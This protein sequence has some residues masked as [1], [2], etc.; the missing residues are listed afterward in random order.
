MQIGLTV[1]VFISKFICLFSS[2][3]RQCQ[4]YYAAFRRRRLSPFVCAVLLLILHCK[5]DYEYVNWFS[6]IFVSSAVACAHS[7][8]SSSFHLSFIFVRE[9]KCCLFTFAIRH[10]AFGIRIN[11]YIN[12]E[13]AKARSFAFLGG[14]FAIRRR[15]LKRVERELHILMCYEMGKK[16]WEKLEPFHTDLSS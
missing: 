5:R 12:R 3:F 6:F 1:I 13:R 14:G 16:S 10:S 4:F 2:T 15:S 9:I 11:K 7:S 8:S